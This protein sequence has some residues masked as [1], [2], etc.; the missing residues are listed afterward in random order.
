MH[1][2]AMFTY[3]RKTKP[4][5]I[6]FVKYVEFYLNLILNEIKNSSQ[7][8][9][10]SIVFKTEEEAETDLPIQEKVDILNTQEVS[11]I[12]ERFSNVLE[13]ILEMTGGHILFALKKHLKCEHCLD[14]LFGETRANSLLHNNSKSLQPST[15]MQDVCKE[16]ETY[17]RNGLSAGHNEFIC[18]FKVED[19]I[20]NILLKVS[21]YAFVH[22][23]MHFIESIDHFSNL[24]QLVVALFAKI[25]L[26]R[27]LKK[28]NEK[29][30]D[31]N[32]LRHI[33]H[34]K[35]W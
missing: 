12:Q 9:K 25:R 4:I 22:N 32:M 33:T 15:F 34:Y 27:E 7:S 8:N 16:C 3:S 24:I 5:P 26:D 31:R 21:D 18:N 30:S 28:I 17:F 11:L 1:L 2:T 20:N 19:M 13:S 29:K 10:S 35:N 23:I 6:N 14:C